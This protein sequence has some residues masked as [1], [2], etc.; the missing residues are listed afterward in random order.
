MILAAVY[1][2]S[3]KQQKDKKYCM[4]DEHKLC[5]SSDFTCKILLELLQMDFSGPS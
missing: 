2:T 3:K 5:S 4:E 1:G